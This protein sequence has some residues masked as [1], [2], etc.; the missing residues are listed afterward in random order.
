MSWHFSMYKVEEAGAEG[1]LGAIVSDE[2]AVEIRDTLLSI[3]ARPVFERQ[4]QARK[5][6]AALESTI[7]RERLTIATPSA[8]LT[9]EPEAMGPKFKGGYRKA[10]RSF[11]PTK[12]DLLNIL[13]HSAKRGVAGLDTAAL[14]ASVNARRTERGELPVSRTLIHD[15]LAD[16]YTGGK[17]ERQEAPKGRA[18][19]R[20][21]YSLAASDETTVVAGEGVRS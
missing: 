4:E 1:T 5:M 11:E 20:L 18:A 10:A 21:L 6:A 9:P 15:V 12:C 13:T 19:R 2:E 17:V 7:A 16:L 14:L 8:P 3:I